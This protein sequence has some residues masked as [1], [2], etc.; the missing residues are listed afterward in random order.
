MKRW[1]PL[2]L[3]GLAVAGLPTAAAQ[4]DGVRRN[5]GGT[6]NLAPLP[7]VY[8]VLAVD[9]YHRIVRLRARSGATA[10]VHVPEGVYDLERLAP[11]DR[12]RVDFRVPNEGDPQLAAATIWPAG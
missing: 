2:L 1:L 4:E 9:D 10:D 3:A 11:G 12:V 5:R 7:A 6:I 8:I